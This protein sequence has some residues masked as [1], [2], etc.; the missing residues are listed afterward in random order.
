MVTKAEGKF[1]GPVPVRNG[2]KEFEVAND[3]LEEGRIIDGAKALCE[4]VRKYLLAH[5]EY[6]GVKLPE[7]K[8]AENLLR[9]YRAAGEE[10][11]DW[12]DQILNACDQIIANRKPSLSLGTSLAA[13]IGVFAKDFTDCNQRGGDL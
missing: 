11:T 5:C 2:W 10:C 7:S 3:L 13:A 9:A 8:T 12:V 1:R 4:G 6:S